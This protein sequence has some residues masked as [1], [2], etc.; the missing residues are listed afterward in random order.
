MTDWWKQYVIFCTYRSG[1]QFREVPAKAAASYAC[2]LGTCLGWYI[3]F[4][5]TT[6]AQPSC[7]HPS[8]FSL[9]K[10]EKIV[11]WFLIFFFF[12]SSSEGISWFLISKLFIQGSDVRAVCLSL[13]Q[14]TVLL[15]AGSGQEQQ[16]LCLF[17]Q[18]MGKGKLYSKRGGKKG[19][20]VG[21]R[22][23]KMMNAW[24]LFTDPFCG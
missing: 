16:G 15:Y 17:W 23:R 5:R 7:S 18:W 11:S 21:S 13:R 10:A 1:V 6:L 22:R 8:P 4:W 19:L 12:F 9:L 3:F 24:M 20:S 14:G 2:V